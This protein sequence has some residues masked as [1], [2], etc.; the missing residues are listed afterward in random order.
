MRI[1]FLLILL[2]F[3]SHSV[4]SQSHV[5]D[6]FKFRTLTTAQGLPDNVVIKSVKDK[7]GFLWV[8]THNGI[9]RFDGKDFQNYDH[10]PNDSTSLRSIWVSDL[11][12]DNQQTIWAST[13]WGVCYYNEREDHFVYINKPSQ[14]QLVFKMPMFVDTGRTLW[15]AAEDG[16]KK[17]NTVSK[18]FTLTALNRIADPQFITADKNHHLIIGTR[19]KGLFEYDVVYDSYKKIDL[20][21]PEGTHYMDAVL[22]NDHLLICTDIGLLQLNADRSVHLYNRQDSMPAQKVEQLMCIQKFIKGFGRNIFVCGT[23]NKKLFLFDETKQVFTTQLLSSSTNPDKF[24]PAVVYHLYDDNNILWISTDRGLGQV[25]LGNQQPQTFFINELRSEGNIPMIKKAVA[26]DP[27]AKKYIWL[28]VLAPFGG[29]LLYDTEKQMIEKEWNTMLRGSAI[30]YNDLRHSNY[31]DIIFGLRN[32]AIDFFDKTRGLF[33]TLKLSHAA[34]CLE[35]ESNGDLWIGTDI[36]LTFVD[37]RT[38]KL[39]DYAGDFDGTDLEKNA[40]GSAFPVFDIRKLNDKKLW[41]AN[42]KYGLFSFDTATKKFLPH[43]QPDNTSFSLLNRCSALE[44][45]GNDSIW[46]GNMAGLS[47]YII[48]QNKFINFNLSKG[49]KSDYVYSIRKDKSNNIWARGNRDVFYFDTKKFSV[50]SMILKTPFDALSYLQRISLVGNDMLLGHDGGFSIFSTIDFTS[51]SN[52][53]PRLQFT[54]FTINGRNIFFDKD[55]AGVRSLRFGH[56]ENQVGIDFTAIEYNYPGDIEYW[57]KLE[58]IEKNWKDAGDKRSINYSNLPPGHYA[59]ALYVINKRNNIKSDVAYFKFIIRPAI[60]QRWWFWPLAALLFV[61]LILIVAMRRIRIIRENEKQKTA[62]NKAMAELETRML[63]S[64]MNP[65]FIFN[66]LNSVQKYIWENKEED[67][68]EYLAR[69]AKLMR[70]ILENSQKATI[71]LEEEIAVTKLYVDLEHR[72]SNGGFEYTIKV[73]PALDQHS[74]RIAPLI[75]QPFIENAIWHGLNKK[76]SKGMLHIHIFEK[77]R[78][79][80]CV[81]DD[82]GVGRNFGNKSEVKQTKSLG[83]EITRQRLFNMIESTK[84]FASVDIKDKFEDGQPAG[85][86]VTLTLPLQIS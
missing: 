31:G 28:S 65:H 71:T 8:A 16:L 6:H 66:S 53:F 32:D 15:V 36:G 75:M 41:L 26:D 47:C 13:E 29:V 37:S 61:F 10:R 62:I 51:S 80:I 56:S 11:V 40:Y 68:A 69:F 72:R 42:P 45:V 59:F 77:E 17:V 22:S 39:R 83:I 25:N 19:G 86:A 79:L 14:M 30:I 43:R 33:K 24:F 4:I 60:W 48:S 52:E 58:G 67:A 20:S 38:G 46:L 9:S 50:I 85:T 84:S 7:R 55:S 70:A 54:G 27:F 57:Y 5:Y 64:Q 34:Y 76:Q 49:L 1:I 81:I 18:T 3:F 2:L 74:V 21:L 35:E 23:Y 73:D 63:R 12:L 44:N 78:Q 82:N